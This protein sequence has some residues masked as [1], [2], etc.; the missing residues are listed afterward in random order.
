MSRPVT[1]F[2][3]QWAD[4]PF[5]TLCQKAKSFGDNPAAIRFTGTVPHSDVQ[6]YFAASD[7]FVFPS[8]REFGGAVVLEAMAMGAVPLIVNYGGPAELVTDET[9][10]RLDIGPRE[11]NRSQPS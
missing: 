11:E 8:I 3:G 9:G 1:L 6:Q 7:L 5:E 2:T 4:L 10:I